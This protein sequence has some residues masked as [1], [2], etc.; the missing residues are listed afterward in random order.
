M[1]ACGCYLNT[2]CHHFLLQCHPHVGTDVCM[3]DHR[4]ARCCIQKD[5]W[6]GPV[7]PDWESSRSH[8][9]Q[10]T[11]PDPCLSSCLRMLWLWGRRT[12]SSSRVFLCC[13][14]GIWYRT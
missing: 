14:A 12:R 7:I 2:E 3:Y 10:G 5:G 8:G 11:L 4:L 13:L 6:T 9:K 1:C